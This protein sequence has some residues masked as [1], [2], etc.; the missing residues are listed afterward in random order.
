M[1]SDWELFKKFF[2]RNCLYCSWPG[3]IAVTG[4]KQSAAR[5]HHNHSVTHSSAHSGNGPSSLPLINIDS[6]MTEILVKE[7]YVHI[8]VCIC[9]SLSGKQTHSYYDGRPHQDEVKQRSSSLWNG[10]DRS[11][12]KKECERMNV[13][14]KMEIWKRWKVAMGKVIVLWWFCD[15]RDCLPLLHTSMSLMQGVKG[16][17]KNE[18][19]WWMRKRWACFQLRQQR[20]R[21]CSPLPD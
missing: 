1:R 10:A 6:K 21:C 2:S 11:L 16:R 19:E 18:G 9:D 12:S 13:R 3:D 14:W 15:C 8:S 7:E 20:V 4:I 17:R 5:E